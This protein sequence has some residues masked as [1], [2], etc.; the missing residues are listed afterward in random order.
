M[1]LFEL[2]QQ[3]TSIKH[4][5]FLHYA[6]RQSNQIDYEYIMRLENRLEYIKI[7]IENKNRSEVS[8]GR[9]YKEVR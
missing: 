6:T 1:N 3:V 5:M 4:K 7:L 9:Q 2:N 8:N